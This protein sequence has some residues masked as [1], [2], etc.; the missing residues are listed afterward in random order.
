MRDRFSIL[1]AEDDD[2]HYSLTKKNL[3]RMCF[4][5]HIRRFTDGRQ[6]LDFLLTKG[7]RDLKRQ[8]RKYILLLDIRMPKVS[9][10]EILE[11]IRLDSELKDI[12]AIMLT[13]S[14]DQCE[15]DRC[16]HLG[17]K[18]YITK[19][20]RTEQFA[21]CVERAAISV[22]LSILDDDGNGDK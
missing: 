20:V 10:V 8:R 14:D 6:M 16:R 18:D 13:C 22:L 7:R 21:R 2:G 4:R 12:P 5:R 3:A 11:R 15:I 9:G 17:V 1:V 19:P